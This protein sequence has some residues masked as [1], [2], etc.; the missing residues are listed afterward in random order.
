MNQQLRDERDWQHDSFRDNEG[1]ECIVFRGE[2]GA[3]DPAV[4]TTRSGSGVAGAPG[5]VLRRIGSADGVIRV[6]SNDRLDLERSERSPAGE[7]RAWLRGGASRAVVI[8][9]AACAW[10]GAF[11]PASAA[12]VSFRH[13]VVPILTK[14]GCNGGG[15]HGKSEGQNGFKLSLLGFEPAEDYE[16]LVLESRGRRLMP[17]A[18]EFSVLLRKA[19][20]ELPHGGGAR[21]ERGSPAYQT[22]VR[23]MEE[24]APGPR[25]DEPQVQRIEVSPREV[26]LARGAEQQLKVTAHFANG[27]KRDVTALATFE[28][29]AK[30]MADV[31]EAGR[32]RL[33]DVPGDAAV[34][35]R[36][37]EHVD[38]FRATVPLGPALADVPPGRNFIDQLVFE[39]LRVLGLPPS[40][41]CDDATFLRRVTLDLAGRLPTAA[42]AEAFL[43]DTSATKR[44]SVI[45]RLL[46][47]DEYADYFANKWAALLRN[48]RKEPPTARGTVAF[49]GWIREHLRRGTPYAEWVGEILTASGNITANPAVAWYRAVAKPQDQLQDV[50][51]LFAGVRLQCAQ[52]HHHPYERWSQQ[53]YYGF[54]AF[55]STLGR[56]PGDEPTEEIVFHQTRAASAENPRTKKPVGPT[57]L[58]GEALSLAPETDPR[59]RLAEWLTKPENPFFA[60]VL[61]NRYWKHFFGRALVEPEDDMRVTNPPSNPALLDALAKHFVD[62]G[63]DLRALCRAICQSEVYQL[64]AEPNAQNGTDRQNFSHFYPRRLPAEVL[65]DAIDAVTAVPT[66]FPASPPG[67][68]AVQ[69]PDD[70]F[71]TG[72]YFLTVFGRPDNASACEC[73]RVSDGSL[74]QR[75][76]LLNAKTIQEK[77]ANSAGLPAKLAN[78]TGPPAEKLRALYL[79]ALSR[80]PTESEASAAREFLAKKPGKEKEAWEDIVWA[81]LNTKEFVFNH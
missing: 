14:N 50:A 34:M 33:T 7:P 48:K 45:D 55:F 59:V 81:V 66:K 35:A 18:P 3:R 67:V 53:D 47:S 29:G 78:E 70:S 52:C 56:K 51:Q 5:R 26:V 63:T 17:S 28:S 65:L 36:F 57:L 76:H 23:W 69:L 8:L 22:L 27:E 21:L 60:K 79:T 41:R 38:V 1:G 31:D 62:S 37:G 44:D 72:S 73:E 71:N 15:C 9:W 42:E 12:P 39:K 20:G 80:L 40:A 6:Q 30:E 2:V 4:R 24:G 74:A 68:R 77:L 19:T 58:G 43:N 75:L 64:S 11:A 13:E 10:V 25:E 16:H 32:V 54:S 49:H 46:A 61:A